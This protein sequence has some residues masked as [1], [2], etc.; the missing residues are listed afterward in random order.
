MPCAINAE[1]WNFTPT[2]EEKELVLQKFGGNL[3]VPENFTRTALAYSPTDED[4][5]SVGDQP[6]C[7]I[8]RQTE[9]FCRTLGIDDPVPLALMLSG[10][11]SS[12]QKEATN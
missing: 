1:R 7:Q 5:D 11:V 10:N 3:I 2:K 12:V 6:A 4:V 8:N 9:I